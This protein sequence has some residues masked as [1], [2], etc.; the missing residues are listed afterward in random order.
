MSTAEVIDYTEAEQ[1]VWVPISKVWVQRYMLA[2]LLRTKVKVCL[3]LLPGQRHLHLSSLQLLPLLFCTLSRKCGD[4]TH[5]VALAGLPQGAILCCCHSLPL[6]LGSMGEHGYTLPLTLHPAK[7]MVCVTGAVGWRVSLQQ[8]CSKSVSLR[9]NHHT[10]HTLLC[11][12]PAAYRLHGTAG[13][14]TLALNR[15]PLITTFLCIELYRG[16]STNSLFLLSLQVNTKQGV[17]KREG[18][19]TRAEIGYYISITNRRNI[20]KTLA[21]W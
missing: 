16:N 3:P 20:S 4:S 6:Q 17:R 11:S 7:G 14:S 12:H 15:G 1:D 9:L 21:Q 13:C 2:P 5:Y 19:M 8:I 18:I 10:A